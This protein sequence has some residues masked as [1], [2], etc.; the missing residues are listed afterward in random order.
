MI[1]LCTSKR[2]PKLYMYTA[3]GYMMLSQFSTDKPTSTIEATGI[4]VP[5]FLE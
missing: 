1:D 3:I 5:Y 4:D 2:D